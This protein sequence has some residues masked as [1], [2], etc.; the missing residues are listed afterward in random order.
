MTGPAIGLHHRVLAFAA[1]LI[2]APKRFRKGTGDIAWFDVSDWWDSDS[3]D[4][5]VGDFGRLRRG[6]S[7][8]GD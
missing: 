4:C 8:L 3:D 2:F 6:L 7:R 5:D 1:F